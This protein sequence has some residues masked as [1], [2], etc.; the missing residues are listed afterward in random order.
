VPTIISYKDGK[1]HNWGYC[2]DSAE[3]INFKWFKILL[4]PGHRLRNK[5]EPVL[6]SMR[7]LR[8]LNKTAEEVATDY[9]RLLWEYTQDDISRFQ[10]DNWRAIYRLKVILTVPAIWSL[11]GKENTRKVAL[12]A[13]LPVDVSLVSEPEAAALA[14]MKEQDGQGGSLQV[15]MPFY[16]R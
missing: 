7:L 11:P 13:G 4:D 12:S 3:K 8:G 2:V 15:N 9:L 6:N 10:G 5:A 14:V 16:Y 1:P